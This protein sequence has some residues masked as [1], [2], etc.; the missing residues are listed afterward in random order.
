MGAVLPNGPLALVLQPGEFYVTVRRG[1]ANMR[2][3][4]LSS[5][6]PP[7]AMRDLQQRQPQAVLEA[8]ALR[9]CL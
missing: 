7:E 4:G 8:L 1:Q 2:L 6:H 9:L 3:A 5:L